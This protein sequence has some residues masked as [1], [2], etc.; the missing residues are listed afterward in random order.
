VGFAPVRNLLKAWLLILGLCAVLGLIGWAFGGLRVAS[1]FVFC[2]LLIGVGAYWAAERV[3]TGSSCQKRPLFIRRWSA[4][5]CGQGSRSRG[6]WQ[7][8]K[9][10]P[11][12]FLLAEA[13]G[14]QGLL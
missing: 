13:W 2:G 8:R 11:S 7:S 4:S 10:H 6:F 12:R 14:R 1:F 3:I 5:R 9:A